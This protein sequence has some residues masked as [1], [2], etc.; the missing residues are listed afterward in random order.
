MRFTSYIPALD[1][2]TLQLDPLSKPV[3]PNIFQR[4]FR[5]VP[6]FSGTGLSALHGN[7]LQSLPEMDGK[8]TLIT[9]SL[10]AK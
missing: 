6:A 3:G 5:R 9:L 8:D 2:L 10:T 1:M 4:S 7:S